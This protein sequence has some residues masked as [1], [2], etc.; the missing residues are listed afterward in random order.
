M[1]RG[2]RNFM[3]FGSSHTGLQRHRLRVEGGR[4]RP[5]AIPTRSGATTRYEIRLF[6]G[7]GLSWDLS[8]NLCA[9]T[10][11]WEPR[12]GRLGRRLGR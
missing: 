12:G 3:R 2:S 8:R 7:L 10:C 6:G 11:A 1:T 4:A 9:G 5:P